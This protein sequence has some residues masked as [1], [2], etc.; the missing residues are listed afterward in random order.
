M[1]PAEVD[2][3]AAR[4]RAAQTG[5]WPSSEG[6]LARLLALSTSTRVFVSHARNDVLALVAEVRRLQEPS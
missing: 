4:A 6:D 5:R 2:A 1:T 3:I